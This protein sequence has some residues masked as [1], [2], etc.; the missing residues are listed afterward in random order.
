MHGKQP[1]IWVGVI[2]FN[3]G[4]GTAVKEDGSVSSNIIECLTSVLPYIKGVCVYDTGSTDDTAML[5]QQFVKQHK[6]RGGVYFSKFVDFATNRNIVI[7]HINNFTKASHILLLD[8]DERFNLRSSIDIKNNDDKKDLLYSILDDKS[9]IDVFNLPIEMHGISWCNPK[10][11]KN[12]KSLRYKMPVH[13]YLNVSADKHRSF[14]FNTFQI[15]NVNN[16]PRKREGDIDP[17]IV[18]NK[19]VEILIKHLEH[20]NTLDGSVPDVAFEKLRTNFYIGK[21]YEDQADYI[22]MYTYYNYVLM[23]SQWDQELFHVSRYSY[24]AERL[25]GITHTC[26]YVDN[27]LNLYLNRPHRY[28][29]LEDIFAYLNSV[30]AY[31]LALTIGRLYVIGQE[32]QQSSDVLFVRNKAYI[33][34]LHLLFEM[35]Y[36][37]GNMGDAKRYNDMYRDACVSGKFLI[38]E[39]DR[40]RIESILKQD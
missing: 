15:D 35:S 39:E 40:D 13:E 1:K 18:L 21:S 3:E 29:A 31:T 10:L 14:Y 6:L 22:G 23:H 12:I 28:E 16:G 27:M 38:T 36:K 34:V 32:Y 8:A 25:L 17:V 5:V 37:T 11:I 9:D 7:R 2:A 4:T 19:D 33:D 24:F 20:L 26:N 30:G